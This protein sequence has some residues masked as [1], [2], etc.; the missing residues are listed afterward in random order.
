[1]KTIEDKNG[2]VECQL[3]WGEYSDMMLHACRRQWYNMKHAV[4]DRGDKKIRKDPW[5]IHIQG[6][7]G[8]YVV[9][10]YLNRFWPPLLG[11][12]KSVDLDPDIEVRSSIAKNPTLQIKATDAELTRCVLVQSP[13]PGHYQFIRKGEAETLPFIIYGWIFAG[14]GRAPGIGFKRDWGD[15]SEWRVSILHLRPIKELLR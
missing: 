6:C 15:E 10:H 3:N 11:E 9:A 4:G 2:R 8:E 14:E 12:F 1:M 13:P 7:G 5:A